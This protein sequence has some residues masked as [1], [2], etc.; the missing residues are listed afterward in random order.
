MQCLYASRFRCDMCGKTADVGP[1][2]SDVVFP[3]SVPDG[4]IVRAGLLDQYNR[5]VVP[6]DDFCDECSAMPFREVV[7]FVRSH[8]RS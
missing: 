5:P 4:W 2:P 1:P 6:L 8:D 3:P 7:E